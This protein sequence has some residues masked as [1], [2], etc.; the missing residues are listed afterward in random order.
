MGGV[1]ERREVGHTT[2]HTTPDGVLVSRRARSGDP[3]TP[4][5]VLR[6]AN[7][8]GLTFSASPGQGVEEV[9]LS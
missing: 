2:Q 3:L 5:A 9:P 4:A 6:L 7:F 1:R 8:G